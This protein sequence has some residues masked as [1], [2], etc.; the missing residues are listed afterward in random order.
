MSLRFRKRLKLL[1]GIYLNLGLNG[2][3]TTIGPRGANINI[4]KGGVYLNTGMPGT[5]ISNREKLFSGNS[6]NQYLNQNNHRDLDTFPPNDEANNID[7]T[8]EIVT[9]SGLIG[10]KELLEVAKKDRAEFGNNLKDAEINFGELQAKLSRKQNGLF[11]KYFTKK[12]TI[13]ELEK[14]I[15]ETAKDLDDLRK[16]YEE[17]KADINIQFDTELEAQYEKLSFCFND[18]IKTCIIWDIVTETTNTELKSSAKSTVE[19][20]KVKFKL[21]SLDFIKSEHSA[22]HLQMANGT[23]LFI[24][25]AFVLLMDRQGE[26]T[27]ID[28]KELTFNFH[29]QRFHEQKESIPSDTKIIDYTWYKVNK[30]GTRDL[31]YVE[32]YQIPV[33]T[34]GAF[35]FTSAN[36]LD[37]TFYISNV[38]LA[39]NFAND[40]NLYLDL[41]NHNGNYSSIGLDSNFQVSPISLTLV[42]LDPLIVQAAQIIVETQMGSTSLIQRKLLI[43]YNR[44]GRIMDQLEQLGVV[45]DSS[46][47]TARKVY[48]KDLNSLVKILEAL[49]EGDTTLTPTQS[50]NGLSNFSKEYYDLL[51]DFVAPITAT[52]KKL[53]NDETLIERIKGSLSETTPQDFLPYCAIYDMCQVLKILCN[54]KFKKNSLEMTGLVLLSTRILPQ[55]DVDF[56]NM[57]YEMVAHSHSQ[58]AFQGIA[59]NMISIACKNNPFQLS[60]DTKNDGKIISSNK[61]DGNLCLPA[62]LKIIDHPLFDEYVATLYRFATI[63]A[64]ADNVVT[65][66]EEATLKGIYQLIH[67]PLPEVNNNS[68]TV[69]EVN[70]KETLEEVLNELETLIGLEVVKHEVTSLIN[71]IKVQKER[72]KVGLKNSQVS[73]HCVFTGSPGTGKTT[74]ARVVAK[75][76]MHL[77]VLKK[78]HLVETDRSGLVAEYTGQTAVKVNK[79]VNSALDGVLFIDEAYSLV[80]ENQDDFGKEAVATLIKRMEDDRDKLIVILAG[81]TNEMKT[82]IDSN[83]GFKSRFNRYIEF[84]DYKP[85]ELE[86][87]YKL[88]CSKLDYILTDDA[89]K[90]LVQVLTSAYA[91][92]DKSFGNGRFVRNTFEKTLERQANRIASVPSLTKEILTTI[93]AD[94]IPETVKP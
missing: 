71:Y 79:T 65:K 37:K 88:L 94:D 59:E 49:K 6:T 60:V 19:R 35:N 86:S 29:Q 67:N 36:G 61:V 3:S 21:D 4:G 8:H 68:L 55:M 18:L 34:Y 69:S 85:S 39:I 40:F 56:T 82:F 81:Y 73:Y 48:T 11:S 7:S 58:G 24:Y 53:A 26:M 78:G 91:T 87:I 45:S 54:G 13:E 14:E 52:T 1:P 57:E 80:G 66:D 15:E 27:L 38:D 2:V 33:V 90:K 46:G 42:D 17:S 84:V 74:I 30:D 23:N 44:A 43:G 72:E 70:S 32:N 89:E 62:A 9:S 28:L 64:K 16:Q 12:E 5:G 50:S 41:L 76:Y 10:L 25:P 20:K 31:R 77:G 22:F 75:I 47:S 51:I 92:K 93:T 63:I 83:P